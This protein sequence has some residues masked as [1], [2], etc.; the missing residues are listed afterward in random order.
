MSQRMKLFT[1]AMAVMVAAP[2]AVQAQDTTETPDWQRKPIVDNTFTIP[3]G[4]YVRV[5][6]AGDSK[7]RVE[8]DGSGLRLEVRAMESGIQ[9]P[10]VRAL[11]LGEGAGGT[12][13]YTVEPRTDAL[14]EIRSVGG[15]S[16]RAVRVRVTLQDDDKKDKEKEAGEPPRP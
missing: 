13:L 10:L 5:M 1:L 8:I 6:L 12:V 7:Y 14:Y 3:V 9:Q 16:G 4:Q 11:L 2:M 15:E